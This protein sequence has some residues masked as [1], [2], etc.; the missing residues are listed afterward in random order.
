MST[1]PFIIYCP[2]ISKGKDSPSQ[3]L[4]I[5]TILFNDYCGPCT[6]TPN[7]LAPPDVKTSCSTNS[8]IAV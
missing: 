6:Y 5:P 2:L 4:Y 3:K 1:N 8:T 7:P